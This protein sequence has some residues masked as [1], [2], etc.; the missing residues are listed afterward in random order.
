MHVENFLIRFNAKLKIKS[1]YPTVILIS[2][3]FGGTKTN[4]VSAKEASY[5]MC[6]LYNH[7]TTL[8]FHSLKTSKNEN[9]ESI[10]IFATLKIST[11]T[12]QQIIGQIRPIIII[13]YNNVTII[14]QYCIRIME[15]VGVM[16]R[17]IN[18]LY[19]FSFR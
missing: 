3:S 17:R 14:I 5:R 13:T 10:L 12:L 18:K 16:L 19:M 6:V 11:A 15:S 4:T 8:F 7:Q 2:D 9:L 1:I